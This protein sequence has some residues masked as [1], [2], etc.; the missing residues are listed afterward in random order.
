V[1]FAEV[2]T[3]KQIEITASQDRGFVER[4]GV[5]AEVVKLLSVD[6][7]AEGTE[8]A[9]A[10]GRGNAPRREEAAGD[11]VGDENTRNGST[12][13]RKG[14]VFDREWSNFGVEWGFLGGERRA[15]E[16]RKGEFEGAGSF[17]PANTRRAWYPSAPCTRKPSRQF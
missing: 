6:F 17:P 8:F 10:G 13:W 4:Q 16:D 9:E 2:R 3:L 12:G 14:K 7:N 11:V 15:A 5:Q 1:S